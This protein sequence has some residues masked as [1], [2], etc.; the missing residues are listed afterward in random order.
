MCTASKNGVGSMYSKGL[1]PENLFKGEYVILAVQIGYCTPSVSDASLI[2]TFTADSRRGLEYTQSA[3]ESGSTTSRLTPAVNKEQ[4][5]SDHRH[6]QDAINQIF[7]FTLKQSRHNFKSWGSNQD[8]FVKNETNTAGTVYENMTARPGVHSGNYLGDCS[9]MPTSGDHACEVIFAAKETSMSKG[10]YLVRK[11][12]RPAWCA[13][14]QSFGRLLF[15]A[16]KWG[17]RL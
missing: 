6:D 5:H 15:D 8:V 13:F 4:L 7:G 11:Y 16:H 9:W 10:N 2:H 17:P 14:G 3:W 12:D 1:N